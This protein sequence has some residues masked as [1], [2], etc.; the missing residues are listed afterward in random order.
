[1]FRT[2]LCWIIT[3]GPSITNHWDTINFSRS[4]CFLCWNYCC[5]NSVEHT[6]PGNSYLATSPLTLG[7]CVHCVCITCLRNLVCFEKRLIYLS[8]YVCIFIF[9]RSRCLES[10]II[11]E[12][13]ILWFKGFLGH[14][15]PALQIEACLLAWAGRIML[16][17]KEVG[18][19]WLV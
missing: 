13:L 7:K 10:H 14:I 15:L 19:W 9:C 3:W 6:H 12:K 18:F 5:G 4:L 16:S 17:R 11:P 2:K 1:M 8:M